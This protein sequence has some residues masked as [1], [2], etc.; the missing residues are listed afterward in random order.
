MDGLHSWHAPTCSYQCET[1][2]EGMIQKRARR[3]TENQL[4]EG[5]K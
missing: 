3:A 1:K 5:T 4:F 2:K